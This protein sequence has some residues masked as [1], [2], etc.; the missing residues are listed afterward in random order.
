M[1]RFLKAHEK[2]EFENRMCTPIS[3]LQK[4]VGPRATVGQIQNGIGIPPANHQT[5]HETGQIWPSKE[6]RQGGN[7]EIRRS[8]GGDFRYIAI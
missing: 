2:G 7:R 6:V 3:D 1:P 4:G 8:Q 5:Q